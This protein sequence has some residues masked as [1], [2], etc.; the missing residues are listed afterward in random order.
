MPPGTPLKDLVTSYKASLVVLSSPTEEVNMKSIAPV[1]I[2][3]ILPMLPWAHAAELAPKPEPPTIPPP[4]GKPGVQQVEVLN[5]PAVQQ[6]AGSVSVENFPATQQVAGSVLVSN[7]PLDENGDIK[8]ATQSPGP[9]FRVIEQ[10]TLEVDYSLL[11]WSEWVDVGDAN[12]L[13]FMYTGHSCANI[14]VE[15]RWSE[16]TPAFGLADDF[17]I[18]DWETI[19]R[20]RDYVG[21]SGT[22]RFVPV[23]GKEARVRVQGRCPGEVAVVTPILFLRRD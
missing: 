3:A 1:L 17:R 7:L 10:L 6:V 13:G 4:E 8:V 19:W 11:N 16:D 14:A 22:P 9:A 12:V 15:W 5:F 18:G 20:L 21:S 23:Q 2:I